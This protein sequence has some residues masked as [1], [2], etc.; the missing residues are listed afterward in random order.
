[1]ARSI[2]RADERAMNEMMAV[3]ASFSAFSL[4][5]STAGTTRRDGIP[6]KEVHLA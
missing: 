1:M 4:L 2:E 5:S 6:E 3:L